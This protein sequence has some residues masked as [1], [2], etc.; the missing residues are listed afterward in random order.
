VT[1]LGEASTAISFQNK[2]LEEV[3]AQLLGQVGDHEALI[4]LIYLRQYGAVIKR[5]ARVRRGIRDRL[6][7]ATAQGFG[8]RYLHSTGQIHKGGPNRAIYLMVTAEPDKDVIVPEHG[9]NFG[10]LERAQAIGDLKALQ[11]LGRRV[12]GIHLESPARFRDLTTALLAS[13]EHI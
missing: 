1:I 11:T 7:K 8:P 3:L 2:S 12:Y 4:F 6:K 9:F 10:I 5:M 13:L